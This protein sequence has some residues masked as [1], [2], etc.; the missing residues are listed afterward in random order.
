MRVDVADLGSDFAK[1]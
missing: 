1:L